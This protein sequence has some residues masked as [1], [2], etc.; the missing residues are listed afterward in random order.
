MQENLKKYCE[1][2][3]VIVMILMTS[4]TVMATVPVEAQLAAQQPTSGPLPAGVTPDITVPTTAYLSVR[5]SILGLGQA[6]LV[7]VYIIPPPNV[8]RKYLNFKLTITKPDATAEVFTFDSYVGDGTSWFAYTPTD[9]GEWKFK[10]EMPGQYFPAGR[11]SLGNIITATTGGTVYSNSVYFQSSSSQERTITVQSDLVASWPGSPLPTDYWVRPV[12][13]EHREWWPIAGDFPWRGPGGH[14]WETY[15]PDTNPYWGGYVS[16]GGAFF[17]PLR[18]TF[19]PWVQ[20][21]NSPHVAWKEQYAIAGILGGDYGVEINDVNI[22]SSSGVGRFPEI[23]Y[24]GRAYQS[25][26]KPGTGK[27]VQTYWRC[28]DLRTGEQFWDR[29]LEAGEAGPT[30]IEYATGVLPGGATAGVH[31]HVTAISLLSISNGF[32]RKYNPWTGAMTSNISIAPLTGTGGTYYMNGY[33]LGVQ[34]IGSTAAPNYRLINWTTFGTSTNFNTRITGNITWPWSTLPDTTDY[35]VGISA[36][37]VKNFLAGAPDNTTISAASLRTGQW[38]W[39]ATVDEWEYAGNTDYA[40]HGKI[41]VLTEQGYF[42]AFNLNTGQLAWKS[43]KFEYPWDQPA[44][45]AYNILSAYGL[46]YRNAYSGVYAFDW[47]D[48]K[49]AWK[50]EAPS[51][52]FETPY[53]NEEGQPRYSTNVGGAIA[54]GKYYIYNTEHSATVPITR[55][56]QLHCINATTG[57][58]IWKVGLPGAASKHTTDIGPIADGCLTLAGSDGYMYVFGKGKSVTSATAEPAVIAQGAAVLIKGTVLD[59]SPAQ[60]GTP[61]VSKESMTTQMEYLHKQMPIAGLWGNET[62]TGVPVALSAIGSDG[63]VINLGTTTTNGYGGT[64]GM[65]WTPPKEDTYT[66]IANFAGDESYGSSM[67]TTALSVG[68][69]PPTSAPPETTPPTDITPLYYGIAA[70]TIAIILAVAVVGAL[71]LRKRS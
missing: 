26:S 59:Q 60:P 49:L 62:I 21:P 67:A 45:G 58:G 16:S 20:A 1:A 27:T 44:F 30:V 52:P 12:P 50:Y 66:I 38:L 35:N 17:G 18:G 28:Y 19:T 36:L 68:P 25:Y 11:Y 3:A 14:D 9:I 71:I 64:F 57:E 65:S 10:F 69:E 48:G 29:L 51:N 41:A 61:C 15:Y 70:A 39:N 5:P 6:I 8:D 31:E 53:V 34:N 56:W 37:V 4:L 55:G 7:N 63:T 40:D 43:D 23:V 13:Y 22:F 32:L 42:V 47:D 46:L 33:V 2:A 24:S 54:D